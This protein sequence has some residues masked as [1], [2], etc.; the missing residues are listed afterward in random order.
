MKKC[1]SL[2]LAVVLMLCT[3]SLGAY[4]DQLATADAAF[5][6]PEAIDGK[7][8][9]GWKN[10]K[11]YRSDKHDSKTPTGIAA[12]WK[13]MYDSTYLYFLVDV[14]DSTIGSAEYEKC[15]NPGDLWTKNTVHIMLDLGNEHTEGYDSNAFYIDVNARGYYWNHYISVANFVKTAVQLTDKGYCVEAAVDIGIYSDFK[16]EKGSQFGLEIWVND[17]ICDNNGRADFVTWN[18]YSD[19]FSN[20]AHLGTVTLGEKPENAEGYNGVICGTDITKLGATLTGITNATGKDMSIIT[21]KNKTA[22]ESVDSF[23]ANYSDDLGVWFGVEFEKEY[24]ISQVIFW[25]GGHW[26]DGGWFGESPKLQVFSDGKWKDVGFSL[27]PDYP[28]DNREAQG[29]THESY[30]FT[31]SENVRC[32][33][34]RIVGK[35]NSFAGH[36]SVSEI[37]VYC[38]GR[39]SEKPPVV[40]PPKT[41]DGM[42]ALLIGSVLAL[43][44]VCLA[45]IKKKRKSIQ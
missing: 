20:T 34:V 44:G 14:T 13:V 8:D 9:N 6:K 41:G 21:N 12:E 28:T 27:T 38:N 42:P 19:A 37:E 7:P 18:G 17:N 43:V 45:L 11:T 3:L 25:E 15:E 36:A 33:K 24:D 29:A 26:N 39:V 4:A 16:A 1:V 30:I 35:N 40:D 23:G 32:S 22:S 2:L 10:A 31:L 5:G